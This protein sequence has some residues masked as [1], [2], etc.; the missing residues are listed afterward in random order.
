MNFFFP[1]QSVPRIAK[2]CLSVFLSI[3]GEF[4]RELFYLYI[5]MTISEKSTE[6]VSNLFFLPCLERGKSCE[7]F[8]F[9]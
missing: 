8:G 9:V 1:S 2:L 4:H 5:K 7:K 3:F 6:I